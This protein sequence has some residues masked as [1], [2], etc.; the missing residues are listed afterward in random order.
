MLKP[1][2]Q[3]N[4]NATKLMQWCNKHRKDI[5]KILSK[6]EEKELIRTYKDTDPDL[7][8]QKLIM[9]NV[10]LVFNI[11]S[12][13]M[14]SVR[15]F[16]DLVQRG[17]YALSYAANKFDPDKD[18][19]FSTYAHNWI[20]KHIWGEYY[21]CTQNEKDITLNAISLNGL[22][23]DFSHNSKDENSSNMGNYLEN[24][25][26]PS[27]NVIADT[28]TQCEANAM[29]NVY[30]QMKQYMLT[31]DFNDTDRLVFD[32]RFINN[33]SE[34]QISTIYNIPKNTV[35]E[36]LQKITSKMKTKLAEMH[37]TSLENVWV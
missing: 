1:I 34:K 5:C 3:D 10:A 18:V 30:D 22:I 26:D 11:A 24:H 21:D 17:L 13:Y 7:M 2:I 8:R 28:E 35:K 4:S 12:K 33:Q 25:L 16:D 36:C 14:S 27:Q 32:G 9:H 29:S 20:F 15:S 23:S 31:A 6:E 19:K 37:I